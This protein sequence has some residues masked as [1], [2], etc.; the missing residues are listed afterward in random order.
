MPIIGL[1]YRG[2]YESVVSEKLLGLEGNESGGVKIMLSDP[3][4]HLIKGGD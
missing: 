3:R 4:E 1:I 2:M